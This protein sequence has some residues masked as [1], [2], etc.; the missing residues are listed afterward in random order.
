MYRAS[1]TL[2]HFIIQQMHKY[3]LRRYNYNYYKIFKIYKI[4]P[5]HFG[6][7]AIL[8]QAALYSTLIMDPLW[9]ATCWKNLEQYFIIILIVSTIYIFVHLLDNKV[10]NV[11][12]NLSSRCFLLARSLMSRKIISP[13]FFKTATSRKFAAFSYFK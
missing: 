1:M 9:S 2:K 5:T 4:T 11:L 10:F 6:S 12:A 13:L 7:Q 8:H 3:I